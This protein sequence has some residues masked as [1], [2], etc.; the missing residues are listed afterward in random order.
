M[1]SYLSLCRS[2][3]WLC[4]VSG[5]SQPRSEVHIC[6]LRNT[7]A[8]PWCKFAFILLSI[9]CSP[10]L[11]SLQSHCMVPSIHL[12]LTLLALY[13]SRCPSHSLSVGCVS[14]QMSC[15]G[16]L[17]WIAIVPSVQSWFIVWF[18]VISPVSPLLTCVALHTLSSHTASHWVGFFY[19]FRCLT[20]TH[21][22]CS[23]LF[24]VSY[25]CLL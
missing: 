20:A 9:C 3:S 11:H 21:F 13:H 10:H 25:I 5:V 1:S 7:T 24:Y 23:A 4:S 2:L 22:C 8:V 19:H 14:S 6:H 16:F 15:C 17:G 18:S 12:L